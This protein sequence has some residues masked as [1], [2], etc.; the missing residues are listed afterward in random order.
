MRKSIKKLHLP[1]LISLLNRTLTDS[2]IIRR[3]LLS[4]DFL[5]L[6][7]L[8]KKLPL[9]TG[10]NWRN[11]P[12]SVLSQK[13]GKKWT[14]PEILPE[15]IDR[16]WLWISGVLNTVSIKIRICSGSAITFTWNLFSGFQK[17]A[18]SD[19][20]IWNGKFIDKNLK[21]PGNKLN[22]VPLFTHEGAAYIGKRRNYCKLST[23]QKCP[24]KHSRLPQKK[25]E[26]DRQA[27]RS[28][29][30]MRNNS[31]TGRKIETLIISKFSYLSGLC[32]IRKGDLQLL[33]RS[34]TLVFT[35]TMHDT[36]IIVLIF[37]NIC[38]PAK[39]RV[40]KKQHT[41]IESGLS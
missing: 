15:I 34:N 28:N 21:K 4:G 23:S 40:S 32:R 39:T 38:L 16:C 5:T 41:G 31:Y 13:W 10:R 17:K 30:L 19:N 8:F 26:E 20:W 9:R 14:N 18:R 2:I 6:R 12:A 29:L 35:K 25:Y 11:S 37:Y 33:N 27:L 7:W 1:I 22:Q 36:I 3:L 24:G